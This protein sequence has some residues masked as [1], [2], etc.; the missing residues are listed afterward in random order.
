MGLP[1]LN[2]SR[3]K[4]AKYLLIQYNERTLMEAFQ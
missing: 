4:L 3:F 2:R 1:V